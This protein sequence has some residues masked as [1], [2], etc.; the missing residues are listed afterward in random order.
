[1]LEEALQRHLHAS[2]WRD[3]APPGG[4]GFVNP[5]GKISYLGLE[6]IQAAILNTLVMLHSG[7]KG[8]RDGALLEQSRLVEMFDSKNLLNIAREP[9]KWRQAN[10]AD[11]KVKEWLE[12]QAF[13]FLR[14]GMMIWVSPCS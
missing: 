6:V 11:G 10:T 2:L 3:D 14:T 1:M 8:A 13:P 12:Q 9:M 7:D 4:L 5:S